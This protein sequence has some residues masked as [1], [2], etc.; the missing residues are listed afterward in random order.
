M[1]FLCYLASLLLIAS[2]S[3]SQGKGPEMVLVEGG[4][5]IMGN[6]YSDNPDERPEHKVTI[7]SFFISKF[8]VSVMEYTNFC[9]QASKK[10]PEGEPNQPVSNVSWDEAVMYCNWVSSISGLDKCY[11][12]T[13]DTSN[14]VRASCDFSKN[15]FRLPTEAEWEYAA[16][17]GIKTKYYA[18]SGGMETDE[19]SWNINNAGNRA[20]E[21][22]SK[23]PNELGIYD[24]T[25]NCMEWCWDWY[26][27]DFYRK[28][29]E[30]NPK[31]PES[32]ASKICRGGNYMCRPD[33]LRNTKRFSLEKIDKEGLAGIRLVR[34]Q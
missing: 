26:K 2:I 9:R 17:G 7:A 10:Y 8:E 28:S 3:F 32:G 31:G 22:G 29:E 15:G 20:H 25:G 13:R 11:E 21:V 1:K 19:V 18:Y 14:N 23:K 12:I 6:D 16:R 33:V 24:M 5:F 34:N 4:S 30:S 27:V